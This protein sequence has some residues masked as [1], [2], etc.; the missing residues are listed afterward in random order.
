M[1]EKFLEKIE[2]I[3][4]SVNRLDDGV[5]TIGLEC[6]PH[7][8]ILLRD[9]DDDR[10]FPYVYLRMRRIEE[11]TDLHDIIPVVLTTI[12]KGDGT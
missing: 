4:Y 7:W 8:H 2:L 10:M 12:T 3:G 9:R 6:C 5:I 11:V 1:M